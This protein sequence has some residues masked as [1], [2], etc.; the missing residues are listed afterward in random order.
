MTQ[1]MMNY[2]KSY[3]NIRKGGKG[4]QHWDYK[5]VQALFRPLNIQLNHFGYTKLN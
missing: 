5:V 1:I 2:L 4:D 3:G